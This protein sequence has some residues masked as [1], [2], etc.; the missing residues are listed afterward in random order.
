MN[1]SSTTILIS[2]EII[3]DVAS[4]ILITFAQMCS[5]FVSSG[6][7]TA[8]RSGGMLRAHILQL[9]HLAKCI[10]GYTKIFSFLHSL[11]S[12][13]INTVDHKSMCL[14]DQCTDRSYVRPGTDGE[15]A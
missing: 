11:K 3:E 5:M 10:V 2:F 14:S 12:P 9:D 13:Q 4:K 8:N 6:I 15:S 1:E 7:L